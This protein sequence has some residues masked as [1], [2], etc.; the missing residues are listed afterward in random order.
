MGVR[1]TIEAK[2]PDGTPVRG[3]SILGINHDAWSAKHREWTGTTGEDGTYTWDNLDK[4]TLGD[5]Y[6]FRIESL[7]PRGGRWTGSVS[8][9]VT[10]PRR[11]TV[12]LSRSD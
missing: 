9:R 12:V 3:A 5:R 10:R 2:L 4:G 7:D 1:V 6:T 11:F 8:D